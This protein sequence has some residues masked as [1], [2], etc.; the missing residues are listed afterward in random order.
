MQCTKCEKKFEEEEYIYVVSY[1][2]VYFDE[3]SQEFDYERDEDTDIL[4]RKCA[5]VLDLDLPKKK[6]EYG[7][8]TKE[9]MLDLLLHCAV[10]HCSTGSDELDHGCMEPYEEVFQILEELG[11]IEKIDGRLYKLK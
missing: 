5:L 11:K 6:S 2:Q 3:V 4:C 8:C 7:D 9:N 1:S 10:S